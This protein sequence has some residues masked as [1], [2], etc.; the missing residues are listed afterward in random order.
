MKRLTILR[1][2]D[3]SPALPGADDFDRPL[4]VKGRQQAREVGEAFKI[5]GLTFD[6]VLASTA[7]RVR[8]TL[9]GVAE[10][11]GPLAIR[12]EEDLY[13]ATERLLLDR[14][15]LTPD[16]VSSLLIV[17]HNPGLE[18]I[19]ADLARDDTHGRR[20][21]V[22]AG[23][24]AAGAAILELQNWASA[25]RAGADLVDLILPREL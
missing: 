21:R 9:D 25:D 20:A 22:I 1:H 19:I 15:R 5:R 18:R 12:F 17:G 2:A 10:T 3:A 13:L 7:L 14:I 8:E 11:Y 4:S 6:L 16:D 24:P 23:L